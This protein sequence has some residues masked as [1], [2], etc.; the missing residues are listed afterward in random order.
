MFYRCKDYP[1]HLD[2]FIA[3]VGGIVG[4]ADGALI[5]VVGALGIASYK[6][7]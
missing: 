5:Y 2:L 3:K 6:D 7:P 1:Y 4:I